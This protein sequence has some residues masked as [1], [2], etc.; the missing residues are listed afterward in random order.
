MAQEHY[1]LGAHAVPLEYHRTLLDDPH[2]MDA[3]DRAIRALIRPG[4]VV[5]DLGA[6]TGILALLA[7]R[8][9]ARVHAVEAG[10]VA[11]LAEA[12][13]RENGL[14]DRVTVHHADLRDLAPPEQVDWVL[15]DF[16]GRFVV[17]DGML[18]VVEGAAAWMKP[19][20]RFCPSAVTLRLAPVQADLS[21]LST[22]EAPLYGLS[23][24]SA[25][26]Y[27]LNTC[28][29]G[30]L[31]ETALLAEARE[32]ARITPP[33]PVGTFDRALSFEVTRAGW[34]RA[35]A[36]WFDA[37][38]T[39]DL[40][41]SSEPGRQTHWGQYLFPVPRTVVQE[42][43]R[44]E[45][46]LRLDQHTEDA[47]WHWSGAVRRG[48]GVV[49]EWALESEQRLG[50]REPAPP[51]PA[52]PLDRDALIA[53]N[54][55]AAQ[56]FLAGRLIEAGEGYQRAIRSLGADQ[57]EL[58]RALFE[59]LGLVELNLGR[60]AAA[61]RDFLRALDGV[62][63]SRQQALRYLVISLHYAGRPQDAAVWRARYEEAYGPHPD[64]P[65]GS[66]AG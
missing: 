27:A 24:A 34:L 54:N 38:L 3:Y 6:G 60:Y 65:P 28:Y 64:L 47:V 12:L 33:A 2:R 49:Q 35:F 19:E 37:Q 13:V 56:A 15:S 32:Y 23:F 17:D 63:A 30:H 1:H 66:G 25:L 62:P 18:G 4:D 40:R 44:I 8:R 26:P 61:S 16:M 52:D 51:H 31:Q 39:P 58:A 43:D 21:A 29:A 50:E 11:R 59:N 46:H 10:P 9:G 41:L 55:D 20:A 5:L 42:G 45:L 57:E 36:G 14:E 22:F 7:A 53:V 48:E